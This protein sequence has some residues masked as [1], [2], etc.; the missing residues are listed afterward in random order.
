MITMKSIGFSDFSASPSDDACCL[1]LLLS[2]DFGRKEGYDHRRI[3]A[4]DAESA[5][6][7]GG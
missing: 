5:K 3:H 6:G 7:A 4:A 2:I 1:G